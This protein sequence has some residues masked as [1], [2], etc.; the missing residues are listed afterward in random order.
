M[1]EKRREFFKFLSAAPAALVAPLVSGARPLTEV[2]SRD[3]VIE[4][5]NVTLMN[6]NITN[7]SIR[8]KGGSEDVVISGIHMTQDSR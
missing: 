2:N 3:I 6:S 7:A 5:K 8:I 4:G 1:N